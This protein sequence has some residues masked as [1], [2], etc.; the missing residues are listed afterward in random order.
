MDERFF[1][2]LL[3]A[4][5]AV[6]APLL[7]AALGELIS[8]TAGVINIELEAMMLC[9]AFGAILGATT[10]GNPALGFITAAVCGVL[11]ASVHGA[12]C[13]I[14]R[15]N[16]VVS[17]VVLNILA[18]GLTTFGVSVVSATG[19]SQAVAAPER[20]AVPGLSTLP[21]IGQA[22]F[23]QSIMVYAAYVLVPVVWWLLNRTTVGLALKATGERPSAADSLGL[24]VRRIRWIALLTCGALAGLGGGLLTL[25]GL[26]FFT[27]NVTAGRGFI[28]L[29]AVI[30]GQWQPFG[31]AAAV[32]LFSITDAFQV[33]AQVL[34]LRVPYQFL[35]MLPYLVTV[36]A[37]AG[38]VRKTR[39]PSA[40]GANYER[41]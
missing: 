19:A 12:A 34:G 40:L 23:A 9:G 32:L 6:S 13:F 21:I 24:G 4:A 41:E 11:V 36:I 37:L 8:E 2:L 3:V 16:Q 15:A 39:A 33:R 18:L 28:A 27:E 5:V 22:F 29:A 26:G 25:G 38:A 30:F 14:F 17:G 10:L 31:T 7:F 20:I 1:A 35:V